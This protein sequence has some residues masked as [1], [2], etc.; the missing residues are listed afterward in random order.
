MTPVVQTDRSADT[1]NCFAASIASVLDLP[2]DEVPNFA[3]IYGDEWEA[4]ADRWLAARGLRFVTVG[5]ASYE[6]FRNTYFGN[7]GE[8][9]VISGPSTYPNRGHACVGRVNEHGG[10][11]IAH[12]PNGGSGPLQGHVW[13]RFIVPAGP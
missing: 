7:H 2:L 1:G 3:G 5:F 11:E 13:V 6:T 9:C 8:C 10:I 12:D 4:G